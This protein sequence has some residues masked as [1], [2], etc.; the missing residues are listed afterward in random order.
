ML[1]LVNIINTLISG[2]FP[3]TVTRER[4]RERERE[5]VIVFTNAWGKC[6][7]TLCTQS[8]KMEC[9]PGNTIIVTKCPWAASRIRITSPNCDKL[10]SRCT[11]NDSNERPFNYCIR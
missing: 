6:R 11:H 9:L 10:L 4:E 1:L 5:I 2:F 8:T 3:F 7:K